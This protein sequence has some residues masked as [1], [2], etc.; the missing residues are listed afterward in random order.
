MLF[1]TFTGEGHSEAESASACDALESAMI[2]VVSDPKS[3][4]YRDKARQI[5]LKLSVSKTNSTYSF[6][7]HY[8][9]VHAKLTTASISL[10]ARSLRLQFAQMIGHQRLAAPGEFPAPL[11]GQVEPELGLVRPLQ[12]SL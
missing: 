7:C 2:A 11:A 1:E 4:Q 10:M 9:R 12:V 6:Y 5:K 3:R 8:I